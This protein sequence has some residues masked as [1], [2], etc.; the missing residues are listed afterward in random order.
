MDRIHELEAE[1]RMAGNIGRVK[2]KAICEYQER[3]RELEQQLLEAP[4]GLTLTATEAERDTA[5]KR[6]EVVE[7]LCRRLANE[8]A[9]LCRLHGWTRNTDL[10]REAREV[11]GD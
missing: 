5:E 3:I 7:D 8:H 6:T 1:L 10:L 4:S 11:L 2:D 9:H